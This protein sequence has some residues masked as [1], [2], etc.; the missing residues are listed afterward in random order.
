MQTQTSR[1]YPAWIYKNV[2]GY[3]AGD[4]GGL[5]TLKT[6][7][8]GNGKRVIEMWLKLITHQLRKNNVSQMV[9]VK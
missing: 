5:K 6:K 7:D 2:K 9:L 4:H 8:K 3:Y 1:R